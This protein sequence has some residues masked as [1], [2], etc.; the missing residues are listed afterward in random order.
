M[1]TTRPAAPMSPLRQRLI[2]DMNMR[3]FSRATQRN[4]IRNVGRFATFLGRPPDAATADDVRRFQVEQQ[5]AGIPAPTMNSIVAAL[6]FFFT[7]TVDRPDLARK[8][9]R[10]AYPRKLPVV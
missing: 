4:Y 10:V 8:L 3:R 1:M 7:H 2:D 9:F 5:G 6:R